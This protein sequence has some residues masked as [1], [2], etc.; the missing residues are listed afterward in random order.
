MSVDWSP[1]SRRAWLLNAYSG[2]PWFATPLHRERR[3]IDDERV[4]AIVAE[5]SPGAGHRR[6]PEVA[7]AQAS[8]ESRTMTNAIAPAA[9]RSP[10]IADSQADEMRR[11]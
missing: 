4:I 2:H 9:G 11:R 10:L 6:D 8:A 7:E 1:P 3:R 5:R